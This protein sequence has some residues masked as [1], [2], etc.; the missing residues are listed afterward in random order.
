MVAPQTRL[1]LLILVAVTAVQPLAMQM[2]VPSLPAIAAD[3]GV[4]AGVAQLAFS[5]SILSMAATTLIYGPVSDR[6]GRRPV[7]L[8]GFAL[9]LLG[10]LVCAL[11]PT[12]EILIA[13]RVLQAV[14]GAA[15]MVLS[16]AI[17][18]DIYDR[19][20][21]ARA[22]A[23]ITMA[24][25]SAPMVAPVIGGVLTDWLGWRWIFWTAGLFGALVALVVYRFLTETLT[26][27]PQPVSPAA[28]LR[29][30]L[31]LLAIPAFSGYTFQAAFSMSVFFA[32][33]AGAPY[34]MVDV[35][36]RPA[37]EFGL[38]FIPIAACY[39]VGNF[40][41]ARLS[42]RVGLDRMIVIGTLLALAAIAII[43][44][45]FLAGYWEPWAL[46]GPFGIASIGNGLSMPNAQ[47]GAVSV[48]PKVAGTASGLS[49]AVQ[50]TM[51]ALAA[52]AVGTMTNGT[53]YPTVGLMGGCALAA[54]AAICVPLWLHRRAPGGTAGTPAA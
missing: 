51:S 44:A 47:A 20:G 21:A 6:L 50:L 42:Q 48:D 7:V 22:I 28:M 4:P 13:G 12:V 23:Y 31:R 34:V 46:F 19:D 35:M 33:M 3:F 2:F 1:F 5:L 14:G 53:P 8:A 45:L 38:Y 54:L 16:R 39:M 41:A 9:F 26:V 29:D 25:V 37:T 10:S 43:V 17:V 18:R 11:A 27:K 30:C 49:T 36:G 15:G 24:M 52:Q 40:A 32:F